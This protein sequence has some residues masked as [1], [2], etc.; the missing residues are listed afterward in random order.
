M[1][2]IDNL[3]IAVEQKHGNEY[4]LNSHYIKKFPNQLAIIEYELAKII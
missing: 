2:D 1:S 3:A 4:Y